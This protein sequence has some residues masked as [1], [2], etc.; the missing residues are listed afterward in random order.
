MG[1]FS[2]LAL[3]SNQALP[4]VL[5]VE[6]DMPQEFTPAARAPLPAPTAEQ[7][8]TDE[9]IATLI[10]KLET[11]IARGPSGSR[12]EENVA[13]LLDRIMAL[14]ASAS[15]DG[16]D[17]VIGMPERF[18]VRAHGAAAAGRSEEARRL[19]D[20]SRSRSISAPIAPSGHEGSSL[21]SAAVPADQAE[22][23]VKKDRPVLPPTSAPPASP[24]ATPAERLDPMR[25][26]QVAAAPLARGAQN[27][28]TAAVA[29]SLPVEAPIRVV[30]NVARGDAARARRA[31]EIKQALTAAGVEVA[32]L[33]AVPAAHVKPGVGY[34]FRSDRDA[35][36]GISRRLEPLL[37]D[38]DPVVLRIHGSVPPPGTIEIAVP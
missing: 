13:K 14:E 26:A 22:A 30:L 4:P 8:Q 9:A 10:D 3:T 17:L 29:P 5:P 35:A 24:N 21:R 20:F 18:A 6:P 36:L 32:G 31:T 7:R 33:A 23:A 27:G 11:M 15:P 37:G 12:P 28:L 2:F 16:L 34:Y 1:Y 25:P 19:E 38:I